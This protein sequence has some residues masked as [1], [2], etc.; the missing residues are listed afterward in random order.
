MKKSLKPRFNKEWMSENAEE[1][2]EI[3]F[4]LYTFADICRLYGIGYYGMRK[5]LEDIWEALSD[6]PGNY[7]TI[8]QFEMIVEHLGP[9]YDLKET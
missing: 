9:P 3:K 5:R 7:F 2:A 4:R 6:K 8:R 1:G